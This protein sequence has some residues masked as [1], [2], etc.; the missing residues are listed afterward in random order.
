MRL[1]LV[2]CV[3][4]AAGC[5]SGPVA[6]LP[7]K[8]QQAIEVNNRGT[9]LFMRGDYAGAIAQYRAALELERSVENEDGIAA[10]LINLSIAYQ[11]QGDR[12]AASAAVA[13][14]LDEGVLRFS[15]QRVAEAALRDAILRFD[16]GDA[17]GS[18]G[19]L[20]RARSACAAPCV[21]AGKLDNME[22]QLAYE[23]GELEAAREAANR[24]LAANRASG[25]RDEVANALRLLGAIEIER[26]DLA[27]ARAALAEAL[28]ID[29]ALAVPPRIYRDL[30]LL[31]RAAAAASDAQAARR[32]YARALA[33]ARA[34]PDER[35]VAEATRLS[36]AL[37]R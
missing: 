17:D 14:I 30:V 6:K 8:R 7:A 36:A 5:A 11:R 13:G 27:A 28:Q 29:K 10:N 12:A 9:A 24:A 4:L 34:V 3:L 16:A 25:D 1:G 37:P 21:L 26:K 33:V 19:S 2:L 18:A 23:R 31:G 20:S 22:A 15:P 32:Y 35:S